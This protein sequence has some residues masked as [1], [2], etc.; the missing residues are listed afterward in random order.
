MDGPVA[1]ALPSRQAGRYWDAAATTWEDEIFSS[2]HNDREGVIAAALRAAAD[3]DATLADFGCGI[4][5]YLPLLG[6]LFGAVHGFEQSPACV[7]VARKKTTA[8]KNV[9]VHVAS[10]SPTQ[11][12]GA[13]DAVLCATAAHTTRRAVWR[14]VLKSAPRESLGE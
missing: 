1:S 8:Q 5:I 13:F 3:P 12:R 7:A 6:K 11:W 4:G 14:G 10:R 2:F 9:S